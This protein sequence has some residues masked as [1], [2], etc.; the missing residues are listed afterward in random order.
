MVF[1]PIEDVQWSSVCS[2]S[3]GSGG[4]ATIDSIFKS[5][6]LT[7]EIK[8][9]KIGLIVGAGGCLMV[10]LPIE[11]VQWSSVCRFA[12]GRE[13]QATIDG[14]SRRHKLSYEIKIVEIG[15]VGGAGGL[16]M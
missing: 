13:G 11:D 12:R 10:F 8:I 15:P 7:Y 14:I 2:I 6:N 16:V 9:V 1:L 3:L 5:H 4:Q